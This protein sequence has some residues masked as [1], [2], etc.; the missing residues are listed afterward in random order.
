MTG[1]AKGG[2]LCG[3]VTF[4]VRGP[5]QSFFLCHCARCRKGT[6]SAHAANLFST[7][8]ALG[9]LTGE[10]LIRSYRVPD[11]RHERS[12][13]STCGGAVPSVQMDGRLLVVPAG[14]LDSEV[15]IR[16]TAHICLADRAEWDHALDEVAGFPGLPG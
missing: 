8:A 1:F 6:G 3:A 5:F 11:T 15:T 7:E 13:C 2:C 16:P 4:E 10:G 14:S 12:F 9:W